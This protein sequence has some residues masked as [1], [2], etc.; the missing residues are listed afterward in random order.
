MKENEKI[1]LLYLNIDFKCLNINIQ[2]VSVT[3]RVKKIL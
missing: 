2:S 3:G 1:F